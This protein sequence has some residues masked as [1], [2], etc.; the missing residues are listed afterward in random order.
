MIHID[1]STII[2]RPVRQVF[3][4]MSTPENEKMFQYGFPISVESTRVPRRVI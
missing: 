1:M 3:D 4:F 2:Y